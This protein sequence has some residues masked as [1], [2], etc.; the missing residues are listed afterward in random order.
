MVEISSGDLDGGDRGEDCSGFCG[1]GGGRYRGED[2]GGGG[3][4]RWWIERISTMV[5]AEK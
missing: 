4:V 5:V 3:G 2:C 1:G